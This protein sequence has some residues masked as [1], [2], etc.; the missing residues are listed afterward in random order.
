MNLKLSSPRYFPNITEMRKGR[1]T[2]PLLSKH[3]SFAH[4]EPGKLPLTGRPATL[5]AEGQGTWMGWSLASF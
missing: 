5:G 3:N 4:R 2:E 1:M